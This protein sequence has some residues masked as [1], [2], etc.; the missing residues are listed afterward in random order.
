M[1]A[2]ASE[3]LKNLLFDYQS[4]AFT[5]EIFLPDVPGDVLVKIIQFIYSGVIDIDPVL[6]SEF[7][8]ICNLLQIK[9][10]IDCVG[11]FNGIKVTGQYKDDIP[12]QVIIPAPKIHNKDTAQKIA[13]SNK[14]AA[15]KKTSLDRLV[16]NLSENEED[17][18]LE[19][20]AIEIEKSQDMVYYEIQEMPE[21]PQN[22]SEEYYVDIDQSEQSDSKSISIV[23]LNS[24]SNNAST[25]DSTIDEQA[26]VEA[27]Q[28]IFNKRLSFNQA[29]EKYNISKTFLW[30]RAKKAG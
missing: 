26:L 29:A 20:E 22:E 19:T 27:M 14:Q 6:M 12:S 30:R 1:L 8:S 15:A 16:A 24:S 4:S 13:V 28:E 25:S 9:G 21:D 23:E 7:V 5:P 10:S 3:F 11:S 17:Q 2:I 18:V